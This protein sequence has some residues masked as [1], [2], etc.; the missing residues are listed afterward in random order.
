M[1]EF[2]LVISAICFGGLIAIMFKISKGFGLLVSYKRYIEEDLERLKDRTCD[3][4][5]VI[6]AIQDYFQIEIHEVPRLDGL[7]K[8]LKVYKKVDKQ[9]STLRTN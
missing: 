6:Q 7:G 2:L 1:L 5:D 4:N 8:K 3:T 9:N